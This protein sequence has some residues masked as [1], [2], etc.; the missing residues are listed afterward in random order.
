[1]TVGGWLESRTPVPPAAL[2]ARVK[3]AIGA[4]WAADV[5]QT[6]VVCEAAAEELLHGLLAAHETGR[7]S[8]LEL[9][10]A[11]ALVTYA[12][13]FS[14]AAGGDLDAEAAGAMR[15]IAALG[16]RFAAPTAA[17]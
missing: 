16:A 6:H 10:A 4:R 9:L 11:D 8:A 13:E 2:A 14:A 7:E 5:A 1:M 15:R 17:E 12:F 3:L